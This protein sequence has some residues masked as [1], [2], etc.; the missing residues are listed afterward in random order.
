ME[1]IVGVLTFSIRDL[2]H[3]IAQ[4]R[5]RGLALAGPGRG[6][7]TSSRLFMDQSWCERATGTLPHRRARWQIR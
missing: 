4:P 2:A 1:L 5:S 7:S 6:A 3:R